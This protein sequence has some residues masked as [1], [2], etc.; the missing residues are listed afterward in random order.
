MLPN[1]TPSPLI[2]RKPEVDQKSLV[3]KVF[4][5]DDK[6]DAQPNY[7]LHPLVVLAIQDAMKDEATH[8]NK[9]QV[10]KFSNEEADFLSDPWNELSKRAGRKANQ[11][12]S[13]TSRR[14]TKRWTPPKFVNIDEIPFRL[15]M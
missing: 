7:K 11:E 3:D 9:V 15:D 2:E 13:T 10:E 12:I 5:D 6:K 4:K 8:K 1:R 14:P